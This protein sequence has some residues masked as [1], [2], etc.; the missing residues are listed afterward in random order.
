MIRNKRQQKLLEIIAE[1][2]IDTQTELTSALEKFGFPVT[3]ATVSRDL[4]DLG[5][6]KIRGKEKNHC[7]ALPGKEFTDGKHY[8]MFRDSMLSVQASQNIIVCKTLPG[9]ANT[10]C[11]LVDKLGIPA[12]IGSVAGDDNFILV[13]DDLSHVEEVAEKLRSYTHD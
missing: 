5:I 7:Y 1:S 12:I 6:V 13:I 9:S 4:K 2:E 11:I 3:Q 10:A 8:N